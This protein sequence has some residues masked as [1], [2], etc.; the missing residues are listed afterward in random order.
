MTDAFDPPP[1]GTEGRSAA[2]LE[3]MPQ[4]GITGLSAGSQPFPHEHPTPGAELGAPD[5]HGMGGE[6]KGQL[7]IVIE[8]F[9]HQPLAMGGLIVFAFLG[10]SSAVIGHVWQ[11]TF[12]QITNQ[13]AT[14][15]TSLHP[16]GTDDIGHDLF[17]QVMRGVEKDIQT[18]L[19]VAVI[20]MFI[21]TTIGAIAGFYRGFADNLL[22]RFVDLVLSVPILAVLIV[23]GHLVSRQAGN[24]FWVAIIIGVLAWTYV[25]RLVRADFLSLRE[26]DFVEAARALGATNRRI[27]LRHMLP[28]AIGP[29][30]VNATLTVATSVILEST[31]SY[32][33]LGI[34]PPEVSLGSLVASGQDA[35]T[36]QWWLF[37]FPA[38]LLIILILSIFLVGDGLREALDPKKTRVRA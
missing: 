14:G 38:G 4:L 25:A 13:Y 23:L 35:A 22:M 12:S 18:A 27:I 30:I 6:V 34:Q 36:T 10:I 37:V 5:A 17:A 16:F 15:P 24:W 21:G 8:R 9:S 19:L 2:E 20:A 1:T 32:L 26:R 29:I 3:S 33:G 31:L 7:R 28:N 11:F